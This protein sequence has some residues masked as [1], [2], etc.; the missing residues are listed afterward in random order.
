MGA[1]MTIEIALPGVKPKM[2]HLPTGRIRPLIY[3]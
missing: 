2:S 3:L 1:I